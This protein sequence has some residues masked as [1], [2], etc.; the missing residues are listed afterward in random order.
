MRDYLVSVP[1]L[2]WHGKSLWGWHC[3]ASQ[4]AAAGAVR[5]EIGKP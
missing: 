2:L 1:A 5:I 3:F 4:I